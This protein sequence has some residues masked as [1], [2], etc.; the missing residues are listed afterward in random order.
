M[1]FRIDPRRRS[2]DAGTA[3]YPL[4]GPYQPY[5]FKPSIR[6]LMSSVS[7]SCNVPVELK[8]VS[9]TNRMTTVQLHPA[10]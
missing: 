6:L 3:D 7:Q 9:L 4:N 5:R 1:S 8:K 10:T 2:R